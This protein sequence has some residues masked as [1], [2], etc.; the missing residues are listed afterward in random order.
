MVFGEVVSEVVAASGPIDVELVLK[1]AVA[2]PVI[3]HVHGFGS[4]LF[5]RV[6]GKVAGSAVVCQYGRRTLREAEFCKGGSNGTCFFAIVEEAA[7]FGFGSTGDNFFHEMGDDV[8]RS[9]WSG[10]CVLWSRW[11]SW[12]FWVV[13]EKEISSDAGATVG[14][15]QI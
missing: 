7:C 1:D 15:G 8:D 10:R 14:F 2:D 3:P 4:A 13:A 6:I 12:I 9:I 11:T 5:D